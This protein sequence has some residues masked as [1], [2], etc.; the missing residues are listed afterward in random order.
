[1]VIFQAV[2]GCSLLSSASGAQCTRWLQ[3]V[4]PKEA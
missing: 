2:K 4:I 3:A 1:M